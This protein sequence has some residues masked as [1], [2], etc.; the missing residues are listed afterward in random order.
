METYLNLMEF[1]QRESDNE[2][3]KFQTARTRRTA[4]RMLFSNSSF[5]L[6]DIN[7]IEVSELLAEFSEKNPEIKPATLKTYGTRFNSS[8][9][10][11]Q[12]AKKTKNIIENTTIEETLDVQFPMRHGKIFVQGLPIDLSKEEYEKICTMLKAFIVEG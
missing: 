10:D 1:L 6:S 9:K 7:N 4:L 3:M 12:L 8:L 5:E 11:F 2:N